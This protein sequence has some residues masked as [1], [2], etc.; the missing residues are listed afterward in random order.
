MRRPTSSLVL[1]LVAAS[2]LAVTVASPASGQTD[3]STTT[4][5]TTSSTTSTTEPAPPPPDQEPPPSDNEGVAPDEVPTEPVAVPPRA[6]P[7]PPTEVDVIVT[8]VVGA[9]L[10]SAKRTL[11]DA[12]RAR[13]AALKLVASQEQ[14]LADLRSKLEGLRADE[15]AAVA[16]LDAAKQR[17]KL[18]ALSAY[19]TSGLEPPI[20]EIVGTPERNDLD[21]RQ[22]F[23][24]AVAETDRRILKEYNAARKNL[25]GNVRELTDAVDDAQLGLDA[26]R[27]A[28]E[29]AQQL[30]DQKDLELDMLQAGGAIAIGGFV[31]PVGE[32]HTF[33][34]TFGAPR[35]T[36]TQYEH[37][38]QGNDIFAPM[39]T[40]LFACERGVVI[41]VGT[42]VLGGTKL[43]LVGATGARY[44]YAHLSGYAPGMVEGKVVEAGEVIGYVGNTG[45]A[46]T[47]PP[48]L[49]FEIHPNGG[50][51]IDPYP[52]LKTV[53][54]AT[55]A[56]RRRTG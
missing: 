53:D 49:H 55:R 28:G 34:S 23:V 25:S 31:F 47:T 5:S 24:S 37:W 11:A 21:R 38:H 1:A 8:K 32:P 42:D 52:I 50:A 39:G 14:H 26:A 43:W 16:R 54:D 29:S 22:G 13:D 56:V 19:T 15:R 3:E 30:H 17:V 20:S 6:A 2:L 12:R 33:A 9:R 44:Y 7:R 48:H 4:S 18:R 41:R 36:G 46:L 45:N 35:M 10:R 40:P 27:A 51:A